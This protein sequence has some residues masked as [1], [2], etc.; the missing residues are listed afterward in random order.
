MK[1]YYEKLHI[2][3]CQVPNHLEG[4]FLANE[5]QSFYYGNVTHFGGVSVGSSCRANGSLLV[6][7][8]VQNKASDKAN[9]FYAES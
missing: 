4:Q 5:A 3:Q 9:K 6:I 8:K 2:H 7:I 1:Q